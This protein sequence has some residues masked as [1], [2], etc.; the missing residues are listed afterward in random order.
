MRCFAFVL[1]VLAVTPAVMTP[2]WAEPAVVSI[3]VYHRFDP[4]AAPGA[5]TVSTPT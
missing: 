2:A 4:V 1:C 5:T 3:L